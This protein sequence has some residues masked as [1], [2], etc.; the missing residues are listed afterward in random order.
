MFEVDVLAGGREGAAAAHVEERLSDGPLFEVVRS[1][2]SCWRAG[3][4]WGAVAAMTPERFQ[5][6]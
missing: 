1:V 6:E 4:S 5:W 2:D 3:R